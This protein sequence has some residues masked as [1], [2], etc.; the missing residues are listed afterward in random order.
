VARASSVR[1]RVAELVGL[2]D[3]LCENASVPRSAITQTAIGSPG[4]YDPRRNARKLTRWPARLGPPGGAGRPAGG[5][6]VLAGDGERRGCRRA[7]RTR[8]GSRP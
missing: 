5:V 2:A 7:G 4:V 6:R 3:L 1:G 8:A